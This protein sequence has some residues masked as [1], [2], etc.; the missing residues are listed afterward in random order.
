MFILLL[1]QTRLEDYCLLCFLVSCMQKS[2]PWNQGQEK[3]FEFADEFVFLV[4]CDSENDT[5]KAFALMS[6]MRKVK[7]RFTLQI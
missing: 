7:V 1:G 6:L 5:S 3:K 2:L 4:L